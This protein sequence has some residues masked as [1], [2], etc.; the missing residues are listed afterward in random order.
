MSVRRLLAT[1]LGMAGLAAVL[2]LLTS[3]PPVSLAALAAAQR[4]ADTAGPDVLVVHLVGL[5]AWAV[6]GWGALGLALTA[7]SAL[8]GA[9]GALAGGALHG[10]LPSGARRAA[11]LV[12]G[13]GLG[14][15]P[16]V[17]GAAVPGLPATTAAAAD[18]VLAAPGPPSAHAVPDWPAP[19]AVPVR[20]GG[21]S[22]APV[23]DWPPAPAPG[24]HVVLRGE[25]LWRIA[26]GHLARTRGHAPSDAEV[27]T[28][29]TAWW[30]ANAEVIGPDP[31]L[32]LPGQ[33]LR[34]PA[35]P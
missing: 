16:P 1:G 24:E 22:T 15:A 11:A 34:P 12:L 25:C 31:D 18:E 33:V 4:T 9:A 20:D 23:P 2:A 14:I 3:A 29:V 21:V 27:A 19:A 28:A 5:L 13:L 32:L 30:Q 17:L 26:E 6:W 10:V 7:C 8:P 35:L